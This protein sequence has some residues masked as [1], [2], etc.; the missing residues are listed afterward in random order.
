MIKEGAMNRYDE[1]WVRT[2]YDQYGQNEW[3]RWEKSPA[4]E[5]KLHVHHHYLRKHIRRGSRV[6]EM[7]AGAGRFTQLLAARGARIVVADI[8][9][10]QLRLNRL[11][12]RRLGYGN[13]VEKWLRLDMCRMNRLP[14]E[15][16]DAVVC[17]GGPLSYAFER[18]EAALREL[19]RVLKPSGTLLVSVMSLW[20]AVH[21]FLPTVMDL[22]PEEHR[23]IIQTGDLHPDHYKACTHRCHMFRAAELRDFLEVGGAVDILSL[24]ASNCLSAAWGAEMQAIRGQPRKWKELLRLELEACREPGCLDMGT[25]IIAAVRKQ[26]SH[27]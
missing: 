24:S 1:K 4:D 3:H 26:E 15:T 16:F 20:G 9:P 12:G 17:Y 13:R 19:V 8:S 5:V 27:T 22:P 6:L 21:Q 11:N 25:H 10:G 23:P 7:G 14:D 2:Y 18:R